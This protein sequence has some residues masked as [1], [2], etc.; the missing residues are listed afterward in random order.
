M[1]TGPM[2]VS[3]YFVLGDLSVFFIQF[4]FYVLYRNIPTVP[5]VVRHSPAYIPNAP[6]PF[7]FHPYKAR[8]HPE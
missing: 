2:N 3:L 4:I 6:N 5:T 8:D 1:N 7:I